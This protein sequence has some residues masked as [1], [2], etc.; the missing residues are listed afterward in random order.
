[1]ET[2]IYPPAAAYEQPVAVPARLRVGNVSLAELVAAPAAW[3]V[4]VKHAPVFKQIV[5]APQIKPHMT[6]MMVESFITFGSIVDRKTVDAIDQ[7]LRRLP[8]SAWPAL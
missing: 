6:S 3:A 2:P 7:D 5:G 4:V 1:M 8:P